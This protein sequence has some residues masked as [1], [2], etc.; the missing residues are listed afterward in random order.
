MLLNLKMRFSA[1]RR[2]NLSFEYIFTRCHSLCP[3]KSIILAIENKNVIYK[4]RIFGIFW[5]SPHAPSFLIKYWMQLF[6][7]HIDVKYNTDEN[8]IHCQKNTKVALWATKTQNSD[9]AITQ[10]VACLT[11]TPRLLGSSPGTDIEFLFELPHWSQVENVGLRWSTIR[12]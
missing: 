5:L 12:S 8:N 4:S 1:F 2:Q 6:Q 9:A 11:H 7:N 10:S 3:L